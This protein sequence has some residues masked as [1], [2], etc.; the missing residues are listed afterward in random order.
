MNARELRPDALVIGA[1][2]AGTSALHAAL[3]RHPEVYA[4]PIK[5]PKFYLCGEAPPPAY[6]GPGDAHSQQEWVW[7]RSRLRAAVRRR[8]PRARSGWRARR[9]ICTTPTHG[10]GSPRSCPRRSSSPSSATRSTGRTRTGCICGSTGSSRSAT[11]SRPAAARTSGSPPGWAPFWHY[12]RM[13]RYGE[14]LADLFSRVDRSR[15]LVLRYRELVADAERDP[16]QGL[17]VPRPRGGPDRHRAAGQL[18][19]VRRT[20]SADRRARPGDPGGGV[21]GQLRRRRRS[22]GRP[23]SRWSAPCTSAARSSD[24]SSTRSSDWRC[25][26]PAPTTSGCSRRSSASPSRT[27]APPSDADR[28]RKGRPSPPEAPSS[29]PACSIPT[30]A[31]HVSS[32][33]ALRGTTLR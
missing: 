8:R 33:R 7:R 17:P 24:R 14:Q 21:R 15:V 5:E 20:G 30:R 25:C 22:G 11:S 10:G 26:R 9:S 27:G 1:P 2:K 29:R 12:R 6:R 23:A 13:G 4:S 18:P 28:S 31:R 19:P 16:G 32:P 3:A